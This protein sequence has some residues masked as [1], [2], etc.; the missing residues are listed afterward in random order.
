MMSLADGYGR[1]HTYLRIAVTDRCNLR[2]AYCMPPQG[3]TQQ[4]R[5]E[6]LTL[7][8]IT[9]VARVCV[10]AGV[11]KIRLTGGEPTMRRDLDVLIG[12]LRELPG[13]RA[14]G[15]TTNGVRLHALARTLQASG[16]TALNISLDTLR[17]ER[18]T[19]ITGRNVLAD[20]LDGI[21]TALACGFTAVK[22]NT[23]LLAGVND[24]ELF[25]FLEFVREKPLGLRFIEYMPFSDNGWSRQHLL[26]AAE[27]IS[28][29]AARYPLQPVADAV[30]G[31]SA[32]EYRIEG[33][34]ATI[35]FITPMSD[36]FC[37][38]C[39]RLR[40]T[41]DG[42]I[43]SCLFSPATVNLRALL[44]EGA[45]DER[46]LAAIRTALAGKAQAHPPA[47]ALVTLNDR[48]MTLIGG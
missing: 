3:V 5:D 9:R 35:G 47:D 13:V 26:P 15:M 31:A 34:R 30:P 16:L 10:A 43:K 42:S 4:E 38:D 37:G 33:F 6:I 19:R 27:A 14:L 32:R 12:W 1:Q 25:D 29:I 7:E 41:A 8:E 39:S 28:R 17:P 24:D 46:L 21:E 18:F 36:A 2:C 20:V 22:L 45:T 23:V 44:R 40:L 48:P 11:S